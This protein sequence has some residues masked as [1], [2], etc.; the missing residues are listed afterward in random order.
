MKLKALTCV[1]CAAGLLGGAQA[2]TDA[3]VEKSFFPYK[4]GVPTVAGLTPGTVID[5][6]NVDQFKAALIPSMAQFI[7][8]G[9]TTLTVGETYSFSISRNYIDATRANLSKAA[10]G[11]S[12]G[13]LT[14]FIAGR[15]FP[16]E[17]DAKDA[18]AGE[19]VFWNFQHNN[20]IGDSYTI[21]P[22]YM[23]YKNMASGKTERSLK[24][25][26]HIIQWKHRVDQEPRPEVSPNPAQLLRSGYLKVHEPQDLK[27]TQL[28]ISRFSDDAKLDEVYLYLGFQRRVR[29]L[30]SNQVTDP[31]LGSDLMV[32]DF[33][34]YNGRMRDMKWEY[35]GTVN[36]LVPFYAHNKQKLAEER[37]EADGFKF[38]DFGGEGEC[39]PNVTWQL[40]KT[41]VIDSVP[42][43][44]NHVISRRTHYVD[45]ETYAL[46]L[47]E[48]YDR[49]GELWKTFI[50][51]Y[52]DSENHL[53]KNA[54]RG[55]A[56]NDGFSI[57][58]VQAKHCTTGSFKVHLEQDMS[59]T[60]LF[61]VQN[62]RGS[63]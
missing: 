18:R 62:M 1:L 36:L 9:Q 31:F 43:D 13:D 54:G 16:Q 60:R 42:V 38:I 49:K 29:R 44:P 12:V 58:D 22:W 10:L 11:A 6:S 7:R 30:A 8:N 27:D 41:Y 4:N 33:E 34:G 21:W 5:K 15:P 23:D 14:G 32:E 17:P 50:V 25:E 56:I 35:K 57:T 24:Q 37:K 2:A 52:T 28:L 55:V 61:S 63:N 48:I 59:P 47:N 45:A 19:K 53:P 26:Y 20:R 51:A 3:D 40:R 39:F 46:S